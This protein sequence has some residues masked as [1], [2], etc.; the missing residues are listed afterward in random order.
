MIPILNKID[1]PNAEPERIAEQMEDTF[2]INPE[3]IIHVSA[4]KGL[5]VPSILPAI[6]DRI[7]P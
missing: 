5:H 7:P 2:A 3:E 1:L 4:K 6:C